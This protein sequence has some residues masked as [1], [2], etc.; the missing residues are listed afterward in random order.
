MTPRLKLDALSKLISGMDPEQALPTGVADPMAQSGGGQFPTASNRY[1]PYADLYSDPLSGFRWG[2]YYPGYGSGGGGSVGSPSAPGGPGGG[3]WF[4]GDPDFTPGQPYSPSSSGGGLDLADPQTLLGFGVPALTLASELGLLGDLDWTDIPGIDAITGALGL[5]TDAANPL[6]EGLDEGDLG[7]WTAS[8][9]ASGGT[10][11]D[12]LSGGAGTDSLVTPSVNVQDFLAGEGLSAVNFSDIP[13]SD[14]VGAGVQ[15]IPGIIDLFSGNAD[16]GTAASLFSGAG[17]LGLAAASAAGIP[18]GTSLLGAGKSLLGMGAAFNPA[19]GIMGLSPLAFF[20]APLV[21][22]SVLQSFDEGNQPRTYTAFEFGDDGLSFSSK[23][24]DGQE[25]GQRGPYGTKVFG[26]LQ[27]NATSKMIE[28]LKTAGFTLDNSK[29]D[30][31]SNRLRYTVVDNPKWADTSFFG[32]EGVAA[33]SPAELIGRMYEDGV[34][35]PPSDR[36]EQEVAADMAAV[37]GSVNEKYNADVLAIAEGL[38]QNW[39]LAAKQLMGRPTKADERLWYEKVGDIPGTGKDATPDFIETLRG[40]EEYDFP[41]LTFAP[42]YTLPDLQPGVAGEY[43]DMAQAYRNA[44]LEDQLTMKA[45]GGRLDP[46]IAR[47]RSQA[48]QLPGH[49]LRGPG[50]GRSDE[51]Q[52]RMADGGEVMLSDGE[53]II[54]ADVVAAMGN[55]SS[56]AGADMLDKMVLDIRGK[57]QKHLGSL[58]GPRRD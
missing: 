22:G 12:N 44:L 18:T 21:I 57:F 50:N 19:M 7:P 46:R 26:Q 8:D 51:I 45:D 48:Q 40:L 34:L 11:A 37:L 20:T 25:Q 39:K 2:T 6:L 15:A 30:T 41:G 43:A 55:G 27:G 28:G 17:S 1:G 32:D 29:A 54:P 3:S 36:S 35:V 16:E 33:T 53:Y 58:P 49:F 52:A 38:D 47:M 4:G 31:S 14:L 23:A 42:D 13:V 24:L 9:N 5:N 10:G 56:N